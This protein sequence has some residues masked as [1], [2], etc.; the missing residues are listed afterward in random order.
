MKVHIQCMNQLDFSIAIS[1]TN[2]ENPCEQFLYLVVFQEQTQQNLS[3]T[4]VS[5]GSLALKTLSFTV[6]A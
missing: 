3:I 6:T 1:K 2:A 5:L 4:F